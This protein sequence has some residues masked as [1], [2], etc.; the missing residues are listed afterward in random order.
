MK[1]GGEYILFMLENI[2]AAP[3]K[4]IYACKVKPISWMSDRDCERLPKT[5]KNSLKLT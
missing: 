2:S 3:L 5:T 4:Y 1:N